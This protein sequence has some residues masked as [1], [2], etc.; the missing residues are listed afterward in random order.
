LRAL[1]VEPASGIC[2]LLSPATVVV[3][4]SGDPLAPRAARSP[5]L[6]LFHD[7][8]RH[9]L[10]IDVGPVDLPPHS[11]AEHSEELVYQL[12]H[13]PFDAWVHGYRAE[14]SDARGTPRTVSDVM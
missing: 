2:E 7:R 13:V 5:Y 3:P 6:R 4:A 12:T 11:M 8:G 14:L 9:E 10:V 1:D